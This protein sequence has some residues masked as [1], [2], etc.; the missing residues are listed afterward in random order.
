M[1]ISFVNE[2]ELS[3]GVFSLWKGFG[4]MVLVLVGDLF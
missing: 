4:D 1:C 2:S 3:K